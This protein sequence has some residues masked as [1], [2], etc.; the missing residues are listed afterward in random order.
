MGGQVAP[1]GPYGGSGSGE[2]C[3]NHWRNYCGYYDYYNYYGF[4][5]FIMEIG[6][7]IITGILVMVIVMTSAMMGIRIKMRTGRQ[8]N[9]PAARHRIPRTRLVELFQLRLEI[10]AERNAGRRC[11][12]SIHQALCGTHQHL[13]A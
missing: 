3:W 8:D 6:V 10:P 9:V 4:I 7:L 5:F 2:L 1:G 12:I 13:T 11:F